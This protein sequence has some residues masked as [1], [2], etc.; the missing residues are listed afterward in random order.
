MVG[1]GV[2]DA[3]ALVAADVGIA[4]GAGTDVAVEAGDVA[5]A[6][7][8]AGRAAY[9]RVLPSGL[10][11]DGTEPLVGGWLKHRGDPAGCRRVGA[12]WRRALTGGRRRADHA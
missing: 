12:D 11:E 10:P 7:R 2:N 3:P 4:I 1:D 8:S 9:Y 5:S 6:E